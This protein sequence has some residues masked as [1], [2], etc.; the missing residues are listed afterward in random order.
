MNIN[1]NLVI[2]NLSKVLKLVDDSESKSPGNNTFHSGVI[3]KNILEANFEMVPLIILKSR[4]FQQNWVI[5]IRP[6]KTIRK[7]KT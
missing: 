2:N 7:R 3:V 4:E 5:S 1:K 6:N